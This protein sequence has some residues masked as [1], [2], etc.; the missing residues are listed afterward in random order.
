MRALLEG[1]AEALAR[2]AVEVALQGNTLA[3]KL[4]LDRL[5]APRRQPAVTLPLPRVASAVELAEAMTAITQSV[6]D[7]ELT[8]A[9]AFD[10]ARVAGHFLKV[11]EARDTEL[12]RKHRAELAARESAA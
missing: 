3:L 11:I 12:G 4:C 2:K 9:E 6:A 10:L 7:G 5:Y 8:P 1:E